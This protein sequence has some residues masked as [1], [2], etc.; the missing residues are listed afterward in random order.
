MSSK[1]DQ[2]EDKPKTHKSFTISAA[3]FAITLLCIQFYILI[4]KDVTALGS[5]E[6]H[7]IPIVQDSFEG[8]FSFQDY[9]KAH[10]GH[11]V[12]GYKI[13]FT[14]NAM[15][16]GL[17]L[18]YFQFGGVLLWTLGASIGAFW[19]NKKLSFGHGFFAIFAAL[20]II[21]TMISPHA[22][23]NSDYSLIAW[24]FGN[25]LGFMLIFIFVDR[26]I[27]TD[28][29]K[30][31]FL[32]LSAL[33]FIYTTVFGRGW[34]QAMLFSTLF[35][36]TITALTYLKL[37]NFQ[38]VRWISASITVGILLLYIYNLGP[39]QLAAKAREPISVK[40]F[41]KFTTGMM[42][43]TLG[44]DFVGRR[45]FENRDSVRLLGLFSIS[46]YATAC[47]LYLRSSLY[48]K[49]I[50]PLL[51]MCFSTVAILAAYLGRGLSIGESAAYF[52][53]WVGESCLGLAGA[54]AILFHARHE[55]ANLM[56]STSV[57]TMLNS[58]LC[59]TCGLIL[60][61]HIIAIKNN[62]RTIEIVQKYDER[63]LKD[64]YSIPDI[65]L[66]SPKTEAAKTLCRR[67]IRCRFR[68]FLDQHNL[69][70]GNERYRPAIDVA[71][72]DAS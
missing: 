68:P 2:L 35:F 42:G 29:H 21:T 8:E 70:P 9:W 18:R 46:V 33:L 7:W 66:E 20:M 26:L 62:F 50:F 19:L 59:L 14:L 41:Y 71:R 34:G 54:V 64:L 12:F 40:G 47:F 5:D 53:R 3:L 48:K 61:T 56:T 55:G 28:N 37:K 63:K 30:K 36:L 52:P 72:T 65:E 13:L 58:A 31:N 24:R 4:V 27:Y 39:E 6:W 51:I 45:N 23:V 32:C 11:R 17:D 43:N 44:F 1:I 10:G 22:W 16:L 60:T 25:I 57:K 49:T 69:I 67:K 15:F 38:K